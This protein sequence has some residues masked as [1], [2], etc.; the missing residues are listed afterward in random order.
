M[1]FIL[2]GTVFII[3]ILFI[4]I[5]PSGAQE[6]SRSVVATSGKYNENSGYSLSSTLGE[7]MTRLFANGGYLLTQ[8]FQQPD[9]GCRRQ[10]ILI[11]SGWNMISSYI[12]PDEPDMAAVFHN[13]NDDILLVKNTLGETYIPA[14]AINL[15]GDW[16]VTEGYSVK[17]SMNTALNMGCTPVDPLTTPVLL[18]TGWNIF[19][20][21]RTSNMDIAAALVSIEGDIL[22]VKDV[23][24]RTF[25]PSF[26]INTIGDMESG[27]GYKAKMANSVVLTYPGN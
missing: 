3:T 18:N 24:G 8:G 21:L 9:D 11:Q 4:A 26:G 6:I 20:Y 12:N 14:F 25:I 1:R 19:A 5:M 17:A 27:Q 22:L 13:I 7:T 23:L 10:A 16:E 2:K 15:I